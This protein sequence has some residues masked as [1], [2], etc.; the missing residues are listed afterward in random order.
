MMRPRRLLGVLGLVV[1]TSMTSCTSFS[2]SRSPSMDKTGWITHCF[3]R[4]LID[5][6]PDAIINTG[7][8]LWGN[9]I[10]KLADTQDELESRVNRRESELRNSPHDSKGALFIRR[11]DL[12]HGSV[13]LL[14]WSSD[15]ST[16]MYRL[17][18]Y[19][20]SSPTRRAYYRR[21]DISIDREVRGIEISTEIA[22]NIR[23]R[24]PNEIPSEPGFCIDQAYIAG[25]SFQV[26]RFGVGV[27]FPEHPGARFEFRSSTGSELN[28]LLERVDGFV[29][30]MLATVAGVERLR[31]GKHPVGSLPGEEYLVAG[32]NK[33]QRAYTFMWEVQGKEE[34]LIEPNLTAG[35]AVLERSNENGK[36]PPPAFKSDKEALELW[37]TI[38]DSI[39]VRPTSSSPRGGNAG[40]SPAP[41]PATP[42]G[43]T[44]GDDYVY[45]EFLSSLKPKDNW[46]DDL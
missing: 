30:N 8:Y 13:G 16:E 24:G 33:G 3:G 44:L 19:F 25:D 41:K 21:G 17:D 7:H 39:R 9:R 46:L 1:L 31:K 42:G 14:S 4:F 34:S 45:E 20:A 43:Q 5:L 40:P 11:V 28:S 29:Q 37:D 36:P 6:P 27:T 12:G 2:S 35:L 18:T 23:S 38:V 22:R 10:E 26:E 15:V 32:S